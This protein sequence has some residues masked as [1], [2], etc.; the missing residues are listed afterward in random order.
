MQPT[1]ALPP[2]LVCAAPFL[3]VLLSIAI[4]P[5]IAPRFWHRH[6]TA[7]SL[8]WIA[9]LLLPWATVHG[10]DQ[11][12]SL[13]WNAILIEYLPFATL[14]TALY[15][16]GG[17]VLIR[18]GP[19]GTPAGNTMM[20]A[21]GV[22]LGVV[23]GQAGAAMVLINP[24]LHANAHRTR[25]VHLPLF[26]ILLVANASGALTPLG[27][28]PLYLGFL[29]GV[30]FFWTTRHLWLPLLTLSACML[31]AFYL[32]DRALARADPPS[33]LKG[34]LHIRGW[35]NA[36]LILLTGATVLAQG[37][38]D[39]G[40]ITL[41]GQ[42]VAVMRIA[43][44]AVFVAVTAVSAAFTPRAI[45]RANDFAWAPMIE[46]AELFL[47]IFIT[48]AP[49][50]AMLH[51]G[52]NGPFAPLLRLT[53]NAAGQPR[54]TAY[55]WL[56]GLLSAFLDN[57]PTYLVFFN[58]A[59]LDPANLSAEQVRTLAALSGGAVFFGGLTY[60]G[61]APN[62]MI[63]GVAAHRGVRMPG[64]FTFMLL[65]ACAGV[66]VFVLLTVLFFR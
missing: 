38:I 8:F 29:E 57:A 59:G 49:V 24:L 64:F 63:R 12:A 4:L 15:V 53:E 40:R 32:L 48:I 54:P 31:A 44:V 25:K 33:P 37:L 65:A 61:N 47:A 6:M 20:L 7:V 1:E 55:F 28:P 21:C 2:S 26:L 3:G 17:G 60:I 9:V 46:V 5:A 13:A 51:A 58:M 18:G 42:P 34:K 30:P 56:A 16:A 10:A 39:A 66:P 36:V 41:A 22:A 11:A 23:M 19:A 50:L 14:L 27:N 45:R 43:A 35:G 52:T 62:M